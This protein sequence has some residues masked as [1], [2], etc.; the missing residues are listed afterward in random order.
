MER[1]SIFRKL[2]LSFAILLSLVLLFTGICLPAKSY[3]ATEPDDPSGTTYTITFKVGGQMYDAYKLNYGQQVSQPVTGDLAGRV[4]LLST[5]NLP[6]D[7]SLGITGPMTLNLQLAPTEAAVMFLQDNPNYN[8]ALATGSDDYYKNKYKGLDVKIITANTQV[9]PLDAAA[10]PVPAG[11]HFSYWANSETATTAFNFSYPI[12]TTTILYP[13]YEQN[14][15]T[16]TFTHYDNT[17][18]TREVNHG[19]Y[20]SD[21]PAP[22]DRPS[23]VANG[24]YDETDGTQT[25]F[26]FIHG[27][28]TGAMSF[29]PLYSSADYELT[30][31]ASAFGSY[32]TYDG[33]TFT[34]FTGKQY[35]ANN[36]NY[37]F[38]VQLNSDYNQF[39]LKAA[40]VTRV[41]TLATSPQVTSGGANG[42]FKCL[43]IGVGSDLT[44]GL[45]GVTKNKYTISFDFAMATGI[46]VQARSAMVEG[47]DYFGVEVDDYG[48]YKSF[49]LEYGKPL[50]F[51][52]V[53]NEKYESKFD[54]NYKDGRNT[55]FD[56]G[57]GYSDVYE[58]YMNSVTNANSLISVDVDTVEC[59]TAVFSGIDHLTLTGFDSPSFDNPLVAWDDITKTARIKKGVQ[60]L[61]SASPIDRDS[62]YIVGMEGVNSLG[63]QYGYYSNINQDVSFTVVETVYV[64]IPA[65]VDGARNI[66]AASDISGSD[67]TYNNADFTWKY[68][69]TKTT[70]QLT[71]QFDFNT[72]FTETMVTPII[73]G[74][75]SAVVNYDEFEFGRV[76]IQNVD[77]NC[78]ITFDA[79]S[80][81]TYTIGLISNDMA[82]LS[83]ETGY[84]GNV[85]EYGGNIGIKITKRTAYSD[86]VIEKDNVYISAPKYA[87]YEVT[88]VDEGGGNYYYLITIETIIGSF[89]VNLQDLQKNTYA[90][91][92][93]GNEYA[94]LNSSTSVAQ[95]GGSFVCIYTLGSAYTNSPVRAGNVLVKNAT[96]GE[97]ITTYEKEVLP[98]QRSITI[99]GITV[100]IQVS[101]IS[102]TKNEYTVSADYL[103]PASFDNAFTSSKTSS[104]KVEHGSSFIFTLKFENP[105]YTQ[106]IDTIQVQ[107]SIN[108]GDFADLAYTSK[109]T[110]TNTLTY[111]IVGVSGNITFNIPTLETNRYT[112]TFYDSDPV[113][114]IYQYNA[115]PHGQR[116]S[117]ATRPTKEGYQCTGWYTAEV[118]GTQFANFGSGI[119]SN[120]TLYARYSSKTFT[121]TFKDN[122][123]PDRS[124]TVNYGRECTLPP[125][126][127]KPGHTQAY[128]VI[129]DG[130]NLHSV[131]QDYTVVA[132][133]I[134]DTYTVRFVYPS[135]PGTNPIIY[136]RVQ[137]TF[138]ANYGTKVQTGGSIQNPVAQGYSFDKW[139]FNYLTEN[140]V[141]N[142][143]IHALFTINTYRVRFINVTQGN[144]VMITHD[145]KYNSTLT[146]L[147]P[148]AD[149]EKRGKYW[150]PYYLG[151]NLM[152]GAQAEQK[153]L[154]DGY[155]L[156]GWYQDSSMSVRYNFDNQIKADT[157]IYGNMYRSKVSVNFYV[158]GEFYLEK[159]V[160]YNTSL[161]TLPEVPRKDGYTQIA[162]RWEIISPAGAM[163]YDNITD[164]MKVQAVYTVNIYTITFKLPSGDSVQRQVSHGGT[165][166]NIPYP[167]TDFGE[168]I[169]V[170]TGL[171]TYVTSDTVVYITVIDFLPFLIVAVAAGVLTFVVISLI[172]A[173]RNMQNS[174]RNVKKVEELFKA[175]KKQD[176]RLTQMNEAKLKAEI[177]AQMKEKEKYKRGSFL[178]D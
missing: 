42:L 178:D 160:D 133:Y 63:T 176:A 88:T 55:Y 57:I 9:T 2:L 145:L 51:T 39:T 112:V 100:P 177:E 111:T 58:T 31:T 77:S 32:G 59:V 128:W 161:L 29:K 116:I 108:S 93:Q 171:T 130:M 157:T 159:L 97:E 98:A 68:R 76:I 166:T 65:S 23:Y 163:T 153:Q 47:T 30:F 44:L 92:M 129:E 87:K 167:D 144:Q 120:L 16:L 99:R 174:I 5:N 123:G 50:Y 71:I 168:V 80:R 43:L 83:I 137:A 150:F 60:F 61:F 28:F 24:W 14:K 143:D 102:L 41:G 78:S 45:S 73:S 1:Q 119:T 136:D 89:Q 22:K 152:T 147:E 21:V 148:V 95:Y 122:V 36:G 34:A 40:N 156:E 54:L 146:E 110:L 149:A 140:I 6:Y 164:T 90:V 155:V 70:G 94:E 114:L 101:V 131:K 52:L 7:F 33:T 10:V 38:Y 79:L 49:Q 154:T 173:I 151:T 109:D 84:A 121:V 27:T 46:S 72:E 3:A 26:N 12:S 125:I 106:A 141:E 132:E 104:E 105:Y 13:K 139:D 15:Y 11:Y 175:I 103:N 69:I 142:T 91:T 81:N 172:L 48:Y 169:V 124:I 158:D 85:V 107:Y 8:A 138:T 53:M 127:P 75:P 165:V 56:A 25:M 117:E 86:A 126:T 96:T 118:G 66:S 18:E 17:V 62:Y 82:T 67:V 64:T 162:P 74:S 19:G 115:V 134:I 20:L 37:T 170:D 35:A 4:W 135:N 113:A